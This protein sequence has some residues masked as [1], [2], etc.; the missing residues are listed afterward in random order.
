MTY[1][2]VL[3]IRQICYKA[4]CSVVYISVMK[5][6]RMQNMLFLSEVD[7]SIDSIN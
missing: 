7:R 2:L 1:G 3:F 5:K 6:E 4:I